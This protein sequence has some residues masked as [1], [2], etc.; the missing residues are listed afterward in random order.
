MLSEI[1]RDH[2][3]DIEKRALDRFKD[4]I[5]SCIIADRRYREYLECKYIK[6]DFGSFDASS[7]KWGEYLNNEG[8]N[9]YYLTDSIKEDDTDTL[10][11][12][13]TT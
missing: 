2:L 10:T 3:D 7:E 9:N 5:D 13:E 1:N 8:L 4:A 11:I 6:K 12:I